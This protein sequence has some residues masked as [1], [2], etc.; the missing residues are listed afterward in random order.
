MIWWLVSIVWIMLALFLSGQAGDSSALLSDGIA[1][2]TYGIIHRFFPGLSYAGYGMLV[3][4]LAH[5]GLHAVLAFAL[6]RAS[7]YSFRRKGAALATALIIALIVALFDELIQL[8]APG[9][10]STVMDAGINVFGV[11]VG[12]SLSAIFP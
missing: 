5:F 3:R 2:P 4:K 12:T 10:Y 7:S 9:R 11:F 6:F 1:E 8:E